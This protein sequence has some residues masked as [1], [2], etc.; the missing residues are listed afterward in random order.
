M[1]VNKKAFKQLDAAE[2]QA[3]EESRRTNDALKR[4]K[5]LE[6]EMKHLQFEKEEKEREIQN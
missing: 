6:E 3:R 5:T 4:A 1:E 2:E